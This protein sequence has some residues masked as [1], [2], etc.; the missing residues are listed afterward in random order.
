[1]LNCILSTLRKNSWGKKSQS[2]ISECSGILITHVPSKKERKKHISES[3]QS[4]PCYFPKTLPKHF[5]VFFYTRAHTHT[6]TSAP[7][8]RHSLQHRPAA[9][10][11][12]VGCGTL[13]SPELGRA[14]GQAGW[15]SPGPRLLGPALCSDVAGG[16]WPGQKQEACN[17]PHPSH[18]VGPRSGSRC[19]D[20]V[21]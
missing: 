14:T 8:K 21:R 19:P 5:D 6:H 12:K 7:L 3:W 9:L 2:Y 10:T 20:H 17:R 4:A 1:M 15:S 18:P 11:G 13:A 16:T